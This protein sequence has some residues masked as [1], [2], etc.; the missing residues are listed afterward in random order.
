M[1]N[2]YL[3]HSATTSLDEKV[4]KDMMP[5]LKENFGNPSSLYSIGQKAFWAVKDS[6]EKA[7]LFL[8]CKPEEVFFTSGATES[9]NLAIFGLIKNFQKNKNFKKVHIITSV[10]EHP[11]VL[12]CFRI[13]ERSKKIE[14]SYINVDKKGL[15]KMDELQKYFKSNTVLVSIMY[16]NNEVGSVQPI[17]KI[18][19]EIEKIKNR[20]KK[21]KSN[22]PIYFHTDAVQAANFF[23]CNI[24]ELKVDLLSLSGHKIYGPKG[25]GLLFV[26]EGVSLS[27]IQFGGH[28]EKGLRSG[29]QN[30]PGIVG[31]GSALIQVLRK[32]EENFKKV[33]QLR[34][35]LVKEIK[36]RIPEIELNGDLKNL[37][38]SHANIIFKGVEG[39]A[40]LLD[41]DFENIFVSTGSACASGNLKASYV[42]LAMGI[43]E[44]KA[45]GAIRFTLGKENTKEEI[46]KVVKTLPTIIKRLRK[47]APK[48]S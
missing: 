2:I 17:D 3:D 14:V 5:Y 24:N 15:I 11:A 27:P 34:N 31:I 25:I 12:E 45:H 40:I 4:L 1:K 35:F 20:R 23:S 36:K 16:V 38:P 42:I 21:E 6:R 33:Q 26:K 28:Q 43:S 18:G 32:K 46:Q 9:N 39:E 37:S 41:L 22:F 7:A 19:Q 30:V 44:E 13:L 10:I 29:T 47:M 8:G 48:L